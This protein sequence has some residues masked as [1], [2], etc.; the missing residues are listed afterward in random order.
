MAIKEI[1]NLWI[2]EAPVAPVAPYLE[3]VGGGTSHVGEGAE[4]EGDGRL[5]FER[6]LV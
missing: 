3:V 4:K 6:Y 2:F 1:Q 5:V